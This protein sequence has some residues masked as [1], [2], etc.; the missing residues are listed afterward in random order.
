MQQSNTKYSTIA[1]SRFDTLEPSSPGKAEVVAVQAQ[2]GHTNINTIRYI[3]PDVDPELAIN[4][5]VL[6]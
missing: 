5:V 1:R 2:L 3:D 6:P 4:Q